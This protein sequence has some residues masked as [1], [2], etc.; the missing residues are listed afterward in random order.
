MGRLNHINGGFIGLNSI[1]T[2]STSS[3]KEPEYV[4]SIMAFAQASA[5][6]GW[7]KQTTYNDYTMRVVSGVPSSGGTKSMSSVFTNNNIY[8]P[9]SVPLTVASHTTSVTEM[10]PHAHP[11]TIQPVPPQSLT[12]GGTTPTTVM[13][14]TLNPTNGST[15]NPSVAA[16]AGHSHT[17]SGTVSISSPYNF[18][19][20]YMDVILA[21]YT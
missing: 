4:N 16:G 5:P 2:K 17:A 20:K 3:G 11:V 19:I 21:K 18:S 1:I 6:T 12:R 15:W 13:F 8:N 14:V 9:V 10:A 7:T